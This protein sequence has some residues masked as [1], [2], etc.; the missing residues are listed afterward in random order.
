[1]YEECDWRLTLKLTVF[2][3]TI[4]LAFF[5]QSAIAESR[6]VATVAIFAAIK[7]MLCLFIDFCFLTKNNAKTVR[8]N[9]VIIFTTMTEFCLREGVPQKLHPLVHEIINVGVS[10]WDNVLEIQ[11]RS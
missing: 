3:N 5:I 1:M 11:L 7:L 9:H 6:H 2:A 8:I 4:T 10:M